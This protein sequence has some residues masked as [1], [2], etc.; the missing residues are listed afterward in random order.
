[1]GGEVMGLPGT[2]RANGT[3]SPEQQ[4]PRVPESLYSSSETRV[5]LQGEVA[6]HVPL[7]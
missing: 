1:M 3:W 5:E 2:H 6:F 4:V 7:W